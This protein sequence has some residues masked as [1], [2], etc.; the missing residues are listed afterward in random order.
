MHVSVAPRHLHTLSLSCSDAGRTSYRVARPRQFDLVQADPC[1]RH[2]LAIEGC[3]VGDKQRM[4]VMQLCSSAPRAF[5]WLVS[6][7]R[8]AEIMMI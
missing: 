7:P 6:A 2:C 8:A 5:Y 4:S 3:R 1:P